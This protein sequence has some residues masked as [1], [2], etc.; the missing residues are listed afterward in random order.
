[1]TLSPKE[2]GALADQLLAVFIPRFDE[3][4]KRTLTV[5]STSSAQLTVK[6]VAE[7]LKLS[8]KTILKYLD[9]GKLAGAN[10]STIG[11]PTWRISQQAV[12]VFLDNRTASQIKG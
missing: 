5:R 11:K 6:E 2:L 4:L 7:Q 10:I 12:Q 8:E 3:A 1:M 9:C